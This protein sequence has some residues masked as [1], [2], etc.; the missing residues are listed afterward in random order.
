MAGRLT[1]SSR[2]P[3]PLHLL[4]CG[5]FV[6]IGLAGCAGGSDRVRDRAAFPAG[7]PIG[8]T[9]QGMASWYGPGFHGRQTA[10]GERYDMHQ[11][12][13]AHRTLPIGS[14]AQVRSLST[15]RAVR[16]RIND[17]GPFTKD[18]IVDVSYAAAQRLGM[19][20]PGTLEVELRV[21]GY[22]GQR[23]RLG[24][25]YVQVGS[26]AEEANA[27]QLAGRLKGSRQVRVVMVGLPHGRRYRVQVGPYR[28][29]TEAL[30]AAE[31][32][33]YELITEALVLRDES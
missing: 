16:V 6:L 15:G 32:L 29:E 19:L 18:R 4:T 25:L 21:I 27:R 8:Y 14:V 9:Q 20:G 30:A 3:R 12:T 24:D 33:S 11:M 7:Y 10:N 2:L 26:F 28:D 31:R 13:A 1:S 17:R 22:Q 23:E 5:L